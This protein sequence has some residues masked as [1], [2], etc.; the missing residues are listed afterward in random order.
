MNLRNRVQLIGNLGSDP[1]VRKFESGQ[2]VAS[3]TV[4]TSDVFRKDKEYIQDTQWH[5]VVSWGRNAEI[6]EEH[7][8]TGCEVVIDGRL[9][10]R[11]YVDKSGIKRRITEIIADSIIYRK[12]IAKLELEND[13]IKKRA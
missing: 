3:F 8:S 9:N 6:A 1:K 11:D 7:L 10:N 12:K 4:A 13:E 5:K 2:K